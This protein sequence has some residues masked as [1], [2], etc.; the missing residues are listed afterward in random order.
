MIPFIN[1][2]LVIGTMICAPVGAAAIV[3]GLWRGIRRIV[4]RKPTDFR[5]FT[6]MH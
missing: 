5:D 3:F 1:T 4:K 6:G 2:T